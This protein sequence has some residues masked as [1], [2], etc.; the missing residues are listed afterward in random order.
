MSPIRP[1]RRAVSRHRAGDYWKVSTCLMES[2]RTLLTLGD[3]EYGNAI[4]ICVIHAVISANDAVTVHHGGARCSSDQ[5]LDAQKLLQ[6]VIRTVPDV[7]LRSFSAVVRAKFEYEYS[8]DIFTPAAARKLL[9][10]AERFYEWAGQQ[11]AYCAYNP[12]P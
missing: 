3:K 6:E 4:G 11:L 5:H 1:P 8:G 12:A 2:A 10:K 9:A 7:A